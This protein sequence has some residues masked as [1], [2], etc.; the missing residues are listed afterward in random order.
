MASIPSSTNAGINVPVESSFLVIS[1][2][3][4]PIIAAVLP[5]QQDGTRLGQFHSRTQPVLV[6][7]QKS[8]GAR[9]GAFVDQARMGYQRGPTPI[10]K[11]GP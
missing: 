1:L 2:V 6:R 7:W 11:P 8:P 3:C 9:V 10:P 5:L 4:V